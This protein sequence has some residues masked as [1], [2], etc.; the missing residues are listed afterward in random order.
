MVRPSVAALAVFSA[1][2]LGVSL[3]QVLFQDSFNTS[4]SLSNNWIFD[5]GHNYVDPEDSSY[6]GPDNW[7]TGEIQSCT[8]ASQ[9]VE[10]D[11]GLFITPLKTKSREWTSSRIETKDTFEPVEGAKMRFEFVFTLF[12]ENTKFMKGIWPAIWMMSAEYRE[13][14]QGYQ[15]GG[16]Y[17]NWPTVGEIDVMENINGEDGIYN[18]VHSTDLHAASEPPT[19][20]VRGV[21]HT[22]TLDIDRF[23]EV[24]SITWCLDGVKTFEVLE[25]ASVFEGGQYASW[26]AL[27][28]APK[29]IILDVAVGGSW[30]G[31]PTGRTRGGPNAGMVVHSV[32]VSQS[33][34]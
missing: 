19:T 11:N 27:A 30:A 13:A 31:A 5:L 23:S 8:D 21:E 14:D 12:D 34:V 33:L 20:F 6:T 9:N 16:K 3:A 2:A 26:E 18:A 1:K 7:G 25:S 10:A 17:W 4:A 15:T 32:E 24:E 29:F 22:I 28:H